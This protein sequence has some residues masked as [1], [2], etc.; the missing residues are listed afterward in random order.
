MDKLHPQTKTSHSL[1]FIILATAADVIQIDLC[2]S[3]WEEFLSGGLAGF[4]VSHVVV[5]PVS[6]GLTLPA[7]DGE[8][9]GDEDEEQTA[10]HGQADDD[11]CKQAGTKRRECVGL[12]WRRRRGRR[13]AH[14]C[15]SLLRAADTPRLCF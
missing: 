1:E 2:R 11:L 5:P 12:C 15:Q 13:G 14:L 4:L 8:E 10:G 9:N 6:E 3:Q 7:D